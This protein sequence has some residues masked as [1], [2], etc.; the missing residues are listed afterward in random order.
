MDAGFS[1]FTLIH[2][3]EKPYFRLRVD[4]EINSEIL[5]QAI[6]GSPRHKEAI[7]DLLINAAKGVSQEALEES[8]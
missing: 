1:K 5:K 2:H 4:L 7:A 6:N 8:C 3:H